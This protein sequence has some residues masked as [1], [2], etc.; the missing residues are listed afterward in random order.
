VSFSNSVPYG[1]ENYSRAGG[2][3][4]V[5][6][7]QGVDKDEMVY[8]RTAKLLESKNELANRP[9]VQVMAKNFKPG[10]RV[11]WKVI[12]Q[13]VDIYIHTS[14]YCHTSS[15]NCFFYQMNLIL[16]DGQ[17]MDMKE[18]KRWSHSLR[19]SWT[20]WGNRHEN[21]KFALVRLRKASI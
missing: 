10:E 8:G 6:I 5:A 4:L 1:S 3:M 15:N 17:K 14:L 9:F 18:I 19:S 16:P 12:V 2:V 11:K 7:G 13:E 20:N 21:G